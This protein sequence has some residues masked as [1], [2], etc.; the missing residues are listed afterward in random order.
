MV[1]VIITSAWGG[2]KTLGAWGMYVQCVCVCE[3]ESVYVCVS[4]HVH[5][6][7]C[8]CICVHVCVSVCVWV[9]VC[10]LEVTKCTFDQILNW[11][12]VES[13]C[14]QTQDKA[15]YRNLKENWRRVW[16][17]DS[18]CPKAAPAGMFG[19]WGAGVSR[20]HILQGMDTALSMLSLQSGTQ[21]GQQIFVEE[22]NEWY[23][24][25]FQGP[26]N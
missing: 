2:L 26:Y 4:V 21:K 19:L 10:I 23:A 17:S 8:V 24:F 5:M 13:V 18:F 11:Q 3:R 7:A 20:C 15:A 6:C 16:W 9:C 14:G 22:M 12:M 25:C 1:K